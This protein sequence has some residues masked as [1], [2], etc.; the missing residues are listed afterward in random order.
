MR[1]MPLSRWPAPMERTGRTCKRGVWLPDTMRRMP[2][3]RWPPPMERTG[4]TCKRVVVTHTLDAYQPRA[5]AAK[6][7][8]AANR[9]PGWRSWLAALKRPR[10]PWLAMGSERLLSQ[11]RQDRQHRHRG[12]PGGL[13][14]HLHRLGALAEGLPLASSVGI[15]RPLHALAEGL[16][17]AEGRRWRTVPDRSRTGVHG[18]AAEVGR[19]ASR[20]VSPAS[21]SMPPTTRRRRSSRYAS[22]RL[23][24][25]VPRRLPER[26]PRRLPRR[27]ARALADPDSERPRSPTQRVQPHALGAIIERPGPPSG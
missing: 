19:W 26:V 16:P 9:G 13:A 25:R 15:V 24:E 11:G 14:P 27:P 12:Q 4:R 5:K 6:T 7:A 18:L 2:L 1:R 17:L 10:S 21:C 8:K 20:G 23:P 22:R 3:S